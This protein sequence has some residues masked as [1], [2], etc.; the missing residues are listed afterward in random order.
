MTP[1]NFIDLT[2]HKFARLT[3]IERVGNGPNWQTYWR[4]LCDCGKFV[5][6]GS[7]HLRSG[8]T[9]SCGCL[10]KEITGQQFRTHGH[11]VGRKNSREF[12]AWTRM[13]QRCCNPNSTR[14]DAWG[15]RGITICDR[16]RKF[17]NFLE[18]MPPHPGKGFSLDRIDNN[19]NYESGNCRW[20]TPK[21]QSN[22]RR[23][24]K[25]HAIAMERFV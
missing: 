11:T 14:F 15:G 17:E 2:L 10:Q 5:I 3:V 12:N 25:A 23:W 19:R 13:R 16:W 18:D 22:N 9:L 8:K 21:E 1:K 4:C 6:V 7:R 24:A 20:A